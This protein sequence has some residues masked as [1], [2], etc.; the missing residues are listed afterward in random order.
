MDAS[1]RGTWYHTHHWSQKEIS[2]GEGSFQLWQLYKCPPTQAP[3]YTET[4]N[5]ILTLNSYTKKKQNDLITQ[6]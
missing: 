4:L 2:K 6:M 1:Y 3:Y 5:E